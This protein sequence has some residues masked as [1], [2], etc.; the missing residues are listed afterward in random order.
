MVLSPVA[1]HDLSS[2]SNLTIF[3]LGSRL[4]LAR[5]QIS[6]SLGSNSSFLPSSFAFSL[7]LSFEASGLCPSA[8]VREWGQA[9][10]PEDGDGVL[11]ISNPSASSFI[12]SSLLMAFWQL[13]LFWLLLCWKR[14]SGSG[15]SSSESSVNSITSTSAAVRRASEDVARRLWAFTRSS[16]M[17]AFFMASG[18]GSKADD[19]KT[20][21]SLKSTA[22]LHVGPGW[23]NVSDVVK[24]ARRVSYRVETRSRQRSQTPARARHHDRCIHVSGKD[25]GSCGNSQLAVVRNRGAPQLQNAV[26]TDLM[27][28]ANGM[29]YG[30]GKQGIYTPPLHLHRSSAH[31]HGTGT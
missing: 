2:A 10:E 20:F 3:A 18:V 16:A 12:D 7:P 28:E 24:P 17:S 13:L 6:T 23:W 29:T 8:L 27:T 11:V 14:S 19:L 25:T 21:L 31:G 26:R 22:F 30:L 1:S 15:S 4:A 9:N 5:F